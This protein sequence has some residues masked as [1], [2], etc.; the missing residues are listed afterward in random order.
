MSLAGMDC[1]QLHPVKGSYSE[2]AQ[3]RYLVER[4]HDQR[5]LI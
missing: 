1:D 3:W 4:I 2:Y 5:Y